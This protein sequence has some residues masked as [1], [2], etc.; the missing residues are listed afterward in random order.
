VLSVAT[1]NA[2]K[3]T[4][5]ATGF[6]DSTIDSKT[7]DLTPYS[8]TAGSTAMTTS[9]VGKAVA[10]WKCGPGSSNPVPAKFLP[11]SCRGR[12]ARLLLKM[13]LRAHFLFPREKAQ[14]SRM[15]ACG[16]LS[17][18]RLSLAFWAWPV[19]AISYLLPGHY[20]PW[21]ALE[22]EVAAF[23]AFTMI[24]V[25]HLAGTGV[26]AIAKESVVLLLLGA[27]VAARSLGMN[28][29][30][31]WADTVLSSLYLW[32]CI[33]AI[34]AG[35]LAGDNL[36]TDDALLP[37]ALVW[38]SASCASVALQLAQWLGVE[39]LMVMAVP[40]PSRP[41]ANL[42]QVNHVATLHALALVGGFY[43]MRVQRPPTALAAG[44]VG[45]ILLGLAMTASRTGLLQ[46]IVVAAMIG[47]GRAR[48]MFHVRRR[49]IV[50]GL[51][52]GV[53]AMAAWVELNRL[54]LLLTEASLQ[55]RAEA[56]PRWAIWQSLLAAIRLSPWVGWGWGGISRAQYEIAA[57]DFPAGR[58]TDYSHNLILD[59]ALWGG[60]PLALLIVAAAGRWVMKVAGRADGL[61]EW[62]ALTSILVV[63]AHAMVEYPHAYAYFLLPVFFLVGYLG[64]RQQGFFLL[65]G[66]GGKLSSVVIT[67][68]CVALLLRIGW[69]FM[70]VQ[71][72]DRWVRM[73]A[74]GYSAERDAPVVP[75]DSWLD[76]W[77]AY[78]RFRL[79]L[80]RPGMSDD[81]LAGMARVAQ[82]FPHPPVL[83]RYAL[84]T[85]LNG[86][87]LEA[88][89]AL[90]AICRLH[91]DARCEEAKQGWAVARQ[92][93]PVLNGIEWPAL[94]YHPPTS[95]S[96]G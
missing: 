79:Q 47:W 5:T 84:A 88:Q 59:L 6:G 93:Y 32:M 38:I 69:D 58:L 45:A 50:V 52:C 83:M 53:G 81:E 90:T 70:R 37:L 71:Q 57:S 35:R 26:G 75:A 29:Q 73:Q 4:V 3:I 48:S 56:G 27:L 87:P 72:A 39:T 76:A 9:D 13:R 85:G 10:V 89:R 23:L 7:I 31:F 2:G 1:T 94:R 16:G 74:A 15:M 67:A 8:D 21:T 77:V 78:Q 18:W 46:I 49:W 55:E 91:I 62:F 54:M 66:V 80:A 96:G 34:Q 61:A 40:T 41:Y 44:I 68:V 17:G 24:G 95:V 22:Q 43:W 64:R 92:R 25:A 36:K 42:G 86:R 19:L 30:G 65:H 60:V 20:P 63:L 11:G 33:I 14:G 28:F 12:F 51:V 82:R